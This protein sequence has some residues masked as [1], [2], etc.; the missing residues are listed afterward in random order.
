M[1]VLVLVSLTDLA[2]WM[3]VLTLLTPDLP[4]LRYTSPHRSLST[5]SPTQGY[6]HNI[7]QGANGHRL[8][9]HGYV[10]TCHVPIIRRAL[11][12]ENNISSPL[13][14]LRRSHW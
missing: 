1:G 2:L 8:R 6:P 14:S 3:P 11:Y 12:T 5:C 10:L 9:R 7:T 13:P 4:E